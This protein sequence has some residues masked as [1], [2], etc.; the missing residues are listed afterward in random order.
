MATSLVQ[1]VLHGTYHAKQ[2]LEKLLRGTFGFT[3][4][5]AGLCGIDY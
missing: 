3:I 4:V 1:I 5:N 2:L